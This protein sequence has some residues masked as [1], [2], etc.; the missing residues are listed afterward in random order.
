M[1][2]VSIFE[3]QYEELINTQ[4][5]KRPI[6]HDLRKR[7][8]EFHQMNEAF[9]NSLSATQVELKTDEDDHWQQ[10]SLFTEKQSK[11]KKDLHE[12]EQMK[13]SIENEIRELQRS[14]F[15]PKQ[16]AKQSIE[17]RDTIDKLF[18]DLV[19]ARKKHQLLHNA[20][21]NVKF[22]SIDAEKLYA[23]HQNE[24][25]HENE[26]LLTLDEKKKKFDEYKQILD[27]QQID[28][29]T[30]RNNF[31]QMRGM[32]THKI[33]VIRRQIDSTRICQ[34]QLNTMNINSQIFPK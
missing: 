19:C 34:T 12:L 11:L 3:I 30:R 9:Y 31:N 29:T 28:L 1:S 7:I 5:Q 32:N 24:E 16:E 14:S 6:I 33:N 17:L 2:T 15:Q 13:I 4:E 8:N 23:M 22:K 26:D 27:K 10:R 20:L 21:L 25:E 18:V